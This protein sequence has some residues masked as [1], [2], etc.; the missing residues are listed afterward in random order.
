MKP[1]KTVLFGGFQIKLGIEKVAAPQEV[2][3]REERIKGE[4][5]GFRLKGT[6]YLGHAVVS[7]DLVNK[8]LSV[9]GLFVI[10]F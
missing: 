6:H 7:D 9:V 3:V 4:K 10:A 5:E 1:Q 2:G 8:K